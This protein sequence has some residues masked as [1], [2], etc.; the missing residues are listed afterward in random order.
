MTIKINKAY[1]PVKRF[2]DIVLSLIG[3]LIL[4][5]P[6]VII[7]LIIKLG[8]GGSVFFKQERV[9]RDHQVFNILK[10]RTM[11]EDAPEKG[12]QIT[13]GQDKRI[14]KVGGFLRKYK[15]DELPQ[16]I[17]VFVGHM[18]LVGPRP[19]VPK[20]VRLY[21]KT[22]SQVLL[23]RPGITDLASIS[24]RSESDILAQAEDP[25]RAYIEEIMP[26][27]LRLNIEYI[28]KMSLLYDLR[29]IF[30]TLKVVVAE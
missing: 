14:T 30:R 21:D 5:I 16:L 20:Y 15:L 27:K 24:Y 8:D 19:E 4:A 2:F 6:M 26:E 28:N 13:I 1:L 9:G 18:S 22:Q 29:L 11:V 17:N 12:G 23:V 10:F 7:A 3:L 25:E